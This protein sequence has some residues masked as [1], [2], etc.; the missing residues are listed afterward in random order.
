M[1]DEITNVDDANFGDEEYTSNIDDST[2]DVGNLK[3][4]KVA[5]ILFAVIA[6]IAGAFFFLREPE[7]P[8]KEVLQ[9]KKLDKDGNE[10]QVPIAKA[11]KEAIQPIVEALEETDINNDITS[12]VEVPDI[13]VPKLPPMENVKIDLPKTESIVP[14]FN[15]PDINVEKAKDPSMATQ[16]KPNAG[17]QQTE[18]ATGN[19]SSGD[20]NAPDFVDN[21]GGGAN[22]QPNSK[23]QEQASMMLLNSGGATEGNADSYVIS[24]T[25][26]KSVEATKVFNTNRTIIQGKIID[27]VLE[28]AINTDFDGSVRGI[29]TEDVYPETG[30]NIVIPKGSRLIGSYSGS[31]SSGQTRVAITWTRL[32]R[33]DSVDIAI[34][35]QATDQ[36]GRAGVPGDVDNKYLEVFNNS[37][38]LSLITIGTAIALEGATGSSEIS[39][40]EDED[41][42][43]TTSG[44]ATDFAANEIIDSIGSTADEI[45]TD[46]INVEPTITVPQGTRINVFVN[47]DLVFPPSDTQNNTMIME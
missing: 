43:E 42:D 19:K 31:V 3:Q 22:G 40:T 39:V 28:T 36:F 15:T 9:E 44:T 32:I 6:V 37:I 21:Q 7:D 35:S 1:A 24:A 26:F 45:L 2:S 33:P 41:G 30:R 4:S 5:V 38:L 25:T 23:G 13:E 12:I 20:I 34:N 29:V 8:N 47:Q 17:N 10:I 46:I 18:N 11:P 16:I 27:A 14:E